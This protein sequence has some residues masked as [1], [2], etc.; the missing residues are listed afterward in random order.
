MNLFVPQHVNETFKVTTSRS[1]ELT[2]LREAFYQAYSM[3]VE[4]FRTGGK[5]LVCGNGGSASDSDHIVAELMKGF[6]LSRPL[7]YEQLI[8][9]REEFGEE[10]ESLARK[11]QGALPAISLSSAGSL[12][13]AIANDVDAEMIFAQQVYGYGKKGDTLLLISTSGNSKNVIQAA[14]VA[15]ILGVSTIALTGETGGELREHCEVVLRA[16]ANETYQIQEYHLCLYHALCIAVEE[17]LFGEQAHVY[18]DHYE[19]G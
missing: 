10:G 15:R 18:A 9:F 11:L 1:P 3:L 4:T 13:T 12:K 6:I 16:P 8:Q 2:P 5:L 19:V 14:K 7:P 17:A